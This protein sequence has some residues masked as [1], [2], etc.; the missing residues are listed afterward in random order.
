M[1]SECDD[2]LARAMCGQLTPAEARVDWRLPVKFACDCPDCPDCG[3]PWCEECGTHYA[4]CRHPGP[5]SEPGEEE[6][7]PCRRGNP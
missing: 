1:D 5:H 2:Y 7:T 6:P 4:D 3:E